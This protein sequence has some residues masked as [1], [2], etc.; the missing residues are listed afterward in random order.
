MTFF[1][2]GFFFADVVFF[3]MIFLYLL[4][5][6]ETDHIASK[7]LSPGGVRRR[8]RLPRGVSRPSMAL[9]WSENG[10]IQVTVKTYDHGP[11]IFM[12]FFECFVL[13]FID[14]HVKKQTKK[15][16]ISDV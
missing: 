5:V 3:S 7:L 1:Q 8:P 12:Y 11:C 16:F 9:L 13:V 6:F 15:C 14:V 10:V 2:K 4:T